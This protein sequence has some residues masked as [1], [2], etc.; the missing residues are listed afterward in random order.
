MFVQARLGSKRLPGKALLN[1]AGLPVLQ[2]VLRALRPVEADV[3]ALLTD[4][5]SASAFQ[6]LAAAEG[7]QLF[8]GPVEDVLERFLRAARLWRV[9]RLVRATGDNPLVSARAVQALIERHGAERCDLSHFLGLP[10]GTGVEIVESAAL[11]K[12]ARLSR[13]PYEREHITTFLYRHPERFRIAEPL[14]PEPWSCPQARVTL[15]TA[16]DYERLQSLFEDL[17]RGEPIE[18]EQLAAWLRGRR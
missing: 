12:A 14:C 10:L 15:D 6:P 3:H 4:R 16:E 17:Y 2:H 9:D 1:L 7:Y 8:I 13:D 11:A 18:I 5:S